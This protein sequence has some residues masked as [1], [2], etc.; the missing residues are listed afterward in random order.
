M[1]WKT[2]L[3]SSLYADYNAASQTENKSSG[4]ACQPHSLWP[5]G[6]PR[7]WRDVSLISV[8]CSPVCLLLPNVSWRGRM[9]NNPRCRGSRDW[10]GSVSFL[11]GPADSREPVLRGA[12]L[13]YGCGC[14]PFP[15]LDVNLE[16]KTNRLE[17]LKKKVD[18]IC[19]CGMHTSISSGNVNRHL[20]LLPYATRKKKSTVT[21]I[22][23]IR[24]RFSLE[25]PSD[26]R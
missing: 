24:V 23:D 22:V 25:S 20:K 21:F 8:F 5:I 14:F 26:C 3:G 15:A 12:V 4:Y 18:L 11:Q 9:K 17:I 10:V 6:R 2:S 13:I 16:V 19:G 7:T 1:A